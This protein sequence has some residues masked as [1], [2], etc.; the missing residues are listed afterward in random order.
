M[1]AETS[2][3]RDDWPPGSQIA[4]APVAEPASVQSDILILR[5]RKL[6]FGPPDIVAVLPVVDTHVVWSAETPALLQ[7]FASRFFV[8]DVSGEFEGFAR[9]VRRFDE[10]QE[11]TR[12]A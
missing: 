5:R 1:T 10:T 12:L 2:L 7:E 6:T 8:L 4:R 11:L 9:P 3:L